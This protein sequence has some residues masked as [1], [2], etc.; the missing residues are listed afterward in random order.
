[1][2]AC[3]RR[4]PRFAALSRTTSSRTRSTRSGAQQ[5][6]RS[7]ATTSRPSGVSSRWC[8][9]AASSWLPANRSSP[10]MASLL[11]MRARS[12]RT[13][14]R[15]GATATARIT[16]DARRGDEARHDRDVPR[17][18]GAFAVS[19]SLI[20][21]T[22]EL[23]GGPG[24]TYNVLDDSGGLGDPVAVTATVRAEL[25]NGSFVS[26]TF[27]DNRP[28]GLNVLVQASSRLALTQAVDTLLQQANQQFNT[29]QW[30]PDAG[31]QLVFDTFRAQPA[32]VWSDLSPYAQTVG[33]AM[34]ALPFGKST[35]RATIGGQS[36]SIQLGFFNQAQ[37]CAYK[38]VTHG[39][40]AAGDDASAFAKLPTPSVTGNVYGP[41]TVPAPID[42][43]SGTMRVDADF[44]TYGGS[45]PYTY[46]QMEAQIPA[47]PVNPKVSVA[48]VGTQVS[49]ASTSLAVPYPASPSSPT[50]QQI[51]ILVVSAATAGAATVTTPAGWTV[52]QA[53]NGGASSPSVYTFWKRAT[54]TESGTLAVTTS[55]AS[56]TWK[57][58]IFSLNAAR[59]SS[60]PYAHKVG[61]VSASTV[62]TITTSSL[63]VDTTAP[64]GD[65]FT[66]AIM[67]GSVTSSANWSAESWA[68]LTGVTG[69]EVQDAGGV[70]IYS[71]SA[72]GG[73]A[74]TFA[75]TTASTTGYAYVTFDIVE[76]QTVDLSASTNLVFAVYV[77][78]AG[79]VSEPYFDAVAAWLTLVDGSSATQHFYMSGP[80]P[81]QSGYS[82]SAGWQYLTCSLAGATINLASIKTW[83]LDI[84]NPTTSYVLPSGPNAYYLGMFR[85]YSLAASIATT[86]WAAVLKIPGV[87]GSA[88]APASIEIDRGG[89]ANT[90]TGMLVYRAPGGTLQ[91][92]P[93]LLPL[94]S[95]VG[96]T[97]APSTFAG[98]YRV[99]I[100]SASDIHTSAGYTLTVAQKI[101]GTTVASIISAA[102]VAKGINFLDC[103]DITLPLV[104]VPSA[105]SVVTYTLTFAGSVGTEAL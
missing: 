69:A 78:S 80:A 8:T 52:L 60:T 105:A 47:Q 10:N 36:T 23:L 59:L 77:G 31:Y 58:T 17:R 33:L 88:Q 66:I 32:T 54:G 21:G 12:G 64:Q 62:T 71:A 46:Y 3:L 35:A 6:C 13:A 83:Q 70:L 4:R 103:G 9:L 102:A 48:A 15:S 56:P 55:S 87:A 45:G 25:T 22:L 72:T 11:R 7:G 61:A 90:E 82:A 99:L 5:S 51:L 49:S 67:Q 18:R 57:A 29:L 91:T 16:C 50:P 104:D 30:T 41:Q 79:N 27:S 94:T 44:Y 101:Y 68:S 76:A 20:Y 38:T 84:N 24:A 73:S 85:A 65:R 74:S 86:P 75:A 93:S 37:Q 95:G 2:H 100:A 43:Q 98:T 97:V 28:I 34:S 26:G 40:S 63:T 42:G 19:D 96:T 39:L 1:M 53:E 81:S 89:G 14:A 92:T